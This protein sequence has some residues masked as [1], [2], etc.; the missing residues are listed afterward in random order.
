MVTWEPLS[1]L[2]HCV[3]PLHGLRH[4]LQ[5]AVPRVLHDVAA[6]FL[7]HNQSDKQCVEHTLY[8]ITALLAQGLSE[9]SY[10]PSVKHVVNFAMQ[11]LLCSQH[12]GG[13]A[14][15]QQRVKVQRQNALNIIF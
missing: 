11:C 7:A 9:W 5:R 4:A 3:H 8:L 6:L 10:R 14:G 2:C 12:H 15:T 13:A 1:E